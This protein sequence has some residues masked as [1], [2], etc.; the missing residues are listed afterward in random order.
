MKL[1]FLGL[2]RQIKK[3]KSNYKFR[4]L[5]RTKIMVEG[6]WTHNF[7]LYHCIFSFTYVT[8]YIIYISTTNIQPIYKRCVPI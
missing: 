7:N 2:T 5:K 1:N 6:V 3:N 8:N 4:V